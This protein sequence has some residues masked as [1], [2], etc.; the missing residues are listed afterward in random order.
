M[1]RVKKAAP[2][3]RVAKKLVKK[4]I[5]LQERRD[6]KREEKASL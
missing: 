6:K 4:E 3:E 5:H 2:P 1:L